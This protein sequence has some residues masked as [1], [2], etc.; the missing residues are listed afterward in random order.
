MKEHL[1]RGYCKNKNKW[2]EGHYIFA[3]YPF[4]N[5]AIKKHWIVAKARGNGGWLVISEKYS[6]LEETIGQFIV[7]E[8]GFDIFEGDIIEE[9]CHGIVTRIF[10]A[11][12][13]R[14]FTRKY[15]TASHSAKWKVIG[16][17]YDNKDLLALNDDLLK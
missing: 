15:D 9:S 4:H 11:E 7:N 3:E 6:V 8:D 2:V 13:I 16:N 14:T 17:V 1:F 5:I 12:D 10:V